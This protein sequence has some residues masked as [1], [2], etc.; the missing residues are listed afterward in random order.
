MENRI[1]L[2]S[3]PE[4]MRTRVKYCLLGVTGQLHLCIHSCIRP[5]HVQSSQ[6]SSTEER[7]DRTSPSLIENILT[8]G[9][10]FTRVSFL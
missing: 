7:R 1:R 4:V 2:L 10:F 6:H 8:V 9:G 5:E 3:D